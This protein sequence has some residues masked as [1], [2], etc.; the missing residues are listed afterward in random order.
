MV[1]TEAV[2]KPLFG[3]RLISDGGAWRLRIRQVKAEVK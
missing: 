3:G 1:V 2:V